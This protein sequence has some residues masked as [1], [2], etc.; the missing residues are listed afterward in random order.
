MV[1][2]GQR[3]LHVRS[4]QYRGLAQGGGPF[5]FLLCLQTQRQLRESYVWYSLQSDAWTYRC[6]GNDFIF[7]IYN[8]FESYTLQ[9]HWHFL[10]FSKVNCLILIC[11]PFESIETTFFRTFSIPCGVGTHL[12]ESCLQHPPQRSINIQEGSQTVNGSGGT[13]MGTWHQ[14]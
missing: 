13:S 3:H 14:V 1:C 4:S 9:T 7:S 10:C 8:I 5:L 12:S 2:S 6:H 11:V